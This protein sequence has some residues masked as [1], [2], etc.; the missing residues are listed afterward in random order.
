MGIKAVMNL[1]NPMNLL[2]LFKRKEQVPTIA[3]AYKR[4]EKV[5]SDIELVGY[6]LEDT[7]DWKRMKQDAE[8]LSKENID[9]YITRL[10]FQSTVFRDELILTLGRMPNVKLKK[11]GMNV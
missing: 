9:K 3:D 1:G 10:K 11:R 8:Q 6:I 4:M 5:V 7:D 2:K